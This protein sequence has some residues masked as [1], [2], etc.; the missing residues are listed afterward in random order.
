[1]RVHPMSMKPDFGFLCAQRVRQCRGKDCCSGNGYCA[2]YYGIARS[3]LLTGSARLDAKGAYWSP[4]L[5]GQSGRS[6]IPVE[7]SEERGKE[8]RTLKSLLHERLLR[9]SSQ[10]IVGWCLRYLNGCG[11]RR[12]DARRR[13]NGS[14]LDKFCGSKEC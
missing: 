9:P 12:D 14:E 8:A 1:M 4:A 10:C 2:C 7:R 3:G 11:S 13:S 6:G 5:K